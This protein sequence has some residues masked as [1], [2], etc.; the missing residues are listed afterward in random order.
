MAESK[1]TR[2]KPT[3]KDN[4]NLKAFTH[5]VAGFVTL[6]QEREDGLRIM[7]RREIRGSLLNLYTFLYLEEDA[8]LDLTE[9]LEADE[10]GAAAILAELNAI[11]ME[12]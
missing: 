11:N 1:P 12:E 6:H 9:L 8:K 7:S 5:L 4:E 3:A 10:D 2:R